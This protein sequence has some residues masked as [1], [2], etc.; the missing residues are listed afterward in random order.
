M[1]IGNII[2]SALTNHPNQLQ[3]SLAVLLRE[4]KELVKTMNDFGVTCTYDELLRFKKSVAVAA[5]KST[6]LTAI[7]KVEDGL[8]QVVV[9]NFDAD[10]ASQNGKLS[11]HSLAVLLAQPDANSQQQEH[12]IPRLKKTDMTKR[13]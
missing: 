4:S 1:L 3:I 5:A 7:S 12:S 11:T 10:I 13:N 6:E 2:T 9:D 8:V